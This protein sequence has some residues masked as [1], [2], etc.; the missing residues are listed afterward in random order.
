MFREKRNFLGFCHNVYRFWPHPKIE[1]NGVVVMVVEG[2]KDIIH[3]L[4]FSLIYNSFGG[5]F[6]QAALLPEF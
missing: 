5:S 6:P 4:H 1:Q 3:T 2:Y